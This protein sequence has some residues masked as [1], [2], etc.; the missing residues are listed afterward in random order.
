M[1][2]SSPMRLRWSPNLHLIG[3]SSSHGYIL[4]TRMKEQMNEW[5]NERTNAHGLIMWWAVC[6]CPC[7]CLL[8]CLFVCWHW[9]WVDGGV[10]V[11]DDLFLCFGRGLLREF[12]VEVGEKGE[13]RDWL[14]HERRLFKA[15]LFNFL[16]VWKR[17]VS[18]SMAP[19]PCNGGPDRTFR[20]NFPNLYD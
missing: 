3:A 6:V 2:Q 17:A 19:F 4:G 12:G 18:L 11:S 1:L 13:R 9:S 20:L 7:A 14:G 5:M 15:P 8:A 16:E 10:L